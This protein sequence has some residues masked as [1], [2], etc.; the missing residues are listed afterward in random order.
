MGLYLVKPDRAAAN[1]ASTIGSGVEKSGSPTSKW[2]TFGR[3]AASAMISRMADRGIPA[4]R[5]ELGFAA[6]SV[7]MLLSAILF[8]PWHHVSGSDF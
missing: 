2:I 4:A 7:V 5:R 3:P 1:A 6:T 8:Q